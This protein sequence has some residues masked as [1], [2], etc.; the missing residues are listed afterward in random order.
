MGTMFGE[1]AFDEVIKSYG[2]ALIEYDCCPYKNRRLGHTH[3]HTHTEEERVKTQ[4]ESGQQ[5]TKEKG[6]EQ[7]LPL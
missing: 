3:T 1:R 6:L 7:S 4:G 2:W 5:Q